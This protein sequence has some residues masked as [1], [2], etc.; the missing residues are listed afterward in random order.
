MG[1]LHWLLVAACLL[2]GAAM[3]GPGHHHGPSDKYQVTEIKPGFFLL[4]GKGGNIALSRGSD[5]ILLVDDDYAE[6]SEALVQ[7]LNHLGGI[8]TLK[9]IVNSHW[10]ADHTQGNKVLGPHAWV[11]AHDN[12]Y[13]RLSQRQEIPFFNR[14]SEP[15]PK[16]AL[17][18]ITYQSQLQLHFNDDTLLL[19]HFPN[20]HT[21][22]DSVIYFTRQNIVHLGDLLFNGFFPFVDMSS[23]GNV[24]KLEQS[25]RHILAELA[26]DAIVIPGHGP[27]A[28]K[29]ALHAYQQMLATSIAEV[30]AH[31]AAGLTKSEI[32]AKGVSRALAGWTKGFIS[33]EA[34]LGFVY[35]SL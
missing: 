34:W 21:D 32:Q 18:E 24:V 26:D 23:G 19:R 16:S 17:P 27:V 11:V 14:V 15:Y 28:D 22:G 12:V 20:S 13:Q 2:A 33:S 31:Q 35:D 7:T 29:A 30:K 10:H 5:G 9:F 4:Q 3:A 1:R 8:E 6:L 25:I